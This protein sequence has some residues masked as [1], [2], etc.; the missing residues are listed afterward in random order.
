MPLPEGVRCFAVAGSTGRH[1]GA[2]K[3][4]LLGD[5]LVP[6]ASA[7][8]QHRSAA[9]TLAFGAGRTHVAWGVG[10]IALLADAGVAAQLRDWLA[11]SATA[12]A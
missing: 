5:G 3:H 9:R 4:R 6:Q 2:L 1:A 11:G 7:L 8:G 12:Q 10:H